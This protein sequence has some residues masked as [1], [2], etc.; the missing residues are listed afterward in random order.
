MLETSEV[1]FSFL[2]AGPQFRLLVPLE[3]SS[4]PE[5]SSPLYIDVGNRSFDWIPAVRD[6]G[7]TEETYDSLNHLRS[8][9]IV[10]CRFTK[11]S[12]Q[13]DRGFGG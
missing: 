10:N 1:S 3:F 9:M 7:L 4:V 8:R 11:E 5:L 12:I 2:T 6:S 13:K